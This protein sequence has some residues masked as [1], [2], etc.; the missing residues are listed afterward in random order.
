M[1][2]DRTV[3]GDCRPWLGVRSTYEVNTVV[4]RKV[5]YIGVQKS[6]ARRGD[7]VEGRVRTNDRYMQN[8]A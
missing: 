7:A 4:F 8:Y 5:R 6:A 2:C 1:H 3:I